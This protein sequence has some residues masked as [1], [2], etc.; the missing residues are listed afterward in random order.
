[1]RKRALELVRDARQVLSGYGRG[2]PVTSLEIDRLLK[3]FHMRVLRADLVDIPAATWPQIGGITKVFIDQAVGPELARYIKLHELGHRI[4][5][6]VDEPTSFAFTG[7]LPE[8]EPIADLFALLGVLDEAETEQGALYVERRIHELV[9]LDD[10]GWQQFRIPW[11]APEVC[12][13]RAILTEADDA[14]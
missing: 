12:A 6:D 9:P 2:K 7:P 8:A 10:R 4:A 13:V 14:S 1:M 3:A 11:L 5:G